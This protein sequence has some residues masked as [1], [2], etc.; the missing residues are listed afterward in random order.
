MW[1]YLASTISEAISGGVIIG[2]ALRKSDAGGRVCAEFFLER[3]IGTSAVREGFASY[4]RSFF[5]AASTAGRW[6][7]S[8]SN[9]I[10]NS[11]S[12]GVVPGIL[13][14]PH[15]RLSTND[16]KRVKFTNCSVA[17]C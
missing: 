5:H 6:N 16:G 4:P 13:Q 7:G 10:G 3:N 8:A 15:D 2:P 17:Y 11:G 1:S 9:A 14:C 12:F